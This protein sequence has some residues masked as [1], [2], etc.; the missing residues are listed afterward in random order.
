MDYNLAWLSYRNIPWYED[1]KFFQTIVTREKHVVIKTAVAELCRAAEEMFGMQPEITDRQERKDNFGK[2]RIC[3]VMDA[4]ISVAGGRIRRTNIHFFRGCFRNFVWGLCTCAEGAEG[5]ALNRAE[6][7]GTAGYA[8]EDV[9]S[10][11]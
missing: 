9:K 4:G 2:N 7:A 1:R 8:F 10:L 11:G 3:L 6:T 5:T